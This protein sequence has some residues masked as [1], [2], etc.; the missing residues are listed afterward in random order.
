GSVEPAGRPGSPVWR[1]DVGSEMFG[2]PLV[3]EGRLYVG[4]DD[5]RVRALDLADG[6]EAWA[7]DAGG[8]VCGAITTDG[9]LLFAL[10][11]DGVLHAVRDGGTAAV[12]EWR[13]DLADTVVLRGVYDAYG[14]APVVVGDALVL[15][16]ADGVVHAVSARDG[17]LLWS[18]RT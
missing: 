1:S 18:F 2:T 14:S 6:S 10:A 4:A 12:P 16:T 9:R 5:G 3:S 15:G 8:P 17:G 11:D 7:F 13:L